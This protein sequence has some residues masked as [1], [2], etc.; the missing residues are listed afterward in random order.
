MDLSHRCLNVTL[1]ISSSTSRYRRPPSEK[2][3]GIV[4]KLLL[5][6]DIGTGT[7]ND[8]ETLLLGSFQK[9]DRIVR[10]AMVKA[11]THRYTVGTERPKLL[12]TSRAG[13]PVTSRLL[14]DLILL[15]V[16]PRF[17]PPFRASL[18][19]TSMPARVGST[20]IEKA[21]YYEAVQK[22]HDAWCR[23]GH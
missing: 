11:G 20:F 6:A 7:Q 9:A 17:R 4:T 8:G 3:C 16:N 12:A 13:N 21:F 14:A 2:P 23:N 10:E 1:L 5:G 22:S 15:P 19:A 18:R